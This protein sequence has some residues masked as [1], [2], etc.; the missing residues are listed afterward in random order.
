M[1]IPADPIPTGHAGLA[2]RLQLGPRVHP[3]AY[4]VS[5]AT[6]IGDVTLGEYASV[7][8]GAVLRGDINRIIVG[9]QSNIQD[10]A[11]VHLSD[12]F[13]AIIGERVTVGHSAIVHACTLEDEVLVGMGAIILDGAEIG[14]RSIIG[15]NALVTVGMK[16]PPG[17]LLLGSP[18]KVARQL[19]LDEQE[20]ISYWALKYVENAR[21]YREAGKPL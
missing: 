17:S 13:P 15:A 14:A 3:T 20:K 5:G 11:V 6:V 10:N 12:D 4:I 18:A 8:F 9:A 21:L 19:S 16:V 7:W 2:R 1:N